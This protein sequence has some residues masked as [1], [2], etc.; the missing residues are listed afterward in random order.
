MH[1]AVGDDGFRSERN[2]ANFSAGVRSSGDMETRSR[3]YSS[4]RARGVA[5]SKRCFAEPGL[6][7][8]SL[9]FHENIHSADAYVGFHL[10]SGRFPFDEDSMR[11]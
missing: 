7:L 10:R 9:S 5:V 3:V 8:L 6:F 1:G 4:S 2:V 11:N